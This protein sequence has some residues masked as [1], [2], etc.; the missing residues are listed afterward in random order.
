MHSSP[1]LR[2][3]WRALIV[4]TALAIASVLYYARYANVGFNFAD[5][6]NYAQIAFELYLGRNPG[7]LAMNYGPLWFQIGAMLFQW[8]G[9]DFTFVRWIFYGAITVTTLLIYSSIVMLTG[10]RR[11]AAVVA[12]VPALVPAFPATA[13]YGLCIML[14]VAAQARLTIRLDSESRLDAALAGAVLSL[15]FQLRPDFGYAFAIL[16]AV[17]IALKTRGRGTT[18]VVAGLSFVVV[19]LPG[20]IAAASK[21]FGLELIGQYLAYPALMLEYL[22]S[23]FRGGSPGAIDASTLLPRQPLSALW[24]NAEATPLAWLVYTPVAGVAGLVVLT[25]G[26]RRREV[27]APRLV[28]LA[29]AAAFPH[30]FLFRPDMAHVANFMPGYAVLA[31]TLTASLWTQS[32]QVWRRIAAGAIALHLAFYT[33]TGLTSRET[34]SIGVAL[35]RDQPFRAGNGVDVLIGSDEAA[36]LSTIRDIIAAN[37]RDGDAIVCLPYCPGIAFMTGRR[38][39]FPEFYVDESFLARKPDWLPRAIDVTR[40]Q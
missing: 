30:Y 39:L 7:D 33:W 32:S 28:A 8:F 14:N 22:T 38:M 5:D 29:A 23:P 34:G 25:I 35:G 24:S 2:Q 27:I 4:P 36:L 11:L 31:A 40:S 18:A 26:D 10:Q 9:V 3:N 19:M 37:S 13:F 17:L 12:V 1:A 15:S 16:L 20:L 6:G 21:G